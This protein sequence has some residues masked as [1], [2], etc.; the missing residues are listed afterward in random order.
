MTGTTI[1]KEYSYIIK[2]I[3]ILLMLIHHFFTFPR[4]IVSGGGTV[5]I[6][7]LRNFSI[8]QRSYVFVFLHS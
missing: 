7:C 2:G 1:S 6:Y 4:W 3:A 8:H 5:L